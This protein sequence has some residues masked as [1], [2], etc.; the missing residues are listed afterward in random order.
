MTIPLLQTKFFIP[1]VRPELVPRGRLIERL[2][3]GLRHNGITGGDCC[4]NPG[5]A[6]KLTLISAPAGFGKTTLLSE[7]ARGRGGGTG[8]TTAPMSIAWLALDEGDNDPSRFLTYLI[9]AIQ[10]T[11]DD[12]GRGV[13]DALRSRHPPSTEVL[14]TA[15]INQI[16]AVPDDL[17]LIL[18]DYHVISAQP[19]HQ[20]LEFLLEH[21][22]DN[23]HIVIATRSD[24]PFRL[25]RL[26]GCGQ[27]TELRQTDLRFTPD[28][29]AAFLNQVMDLELPSDDVVALAQRTEG[30]IAGLQMAAISIHG[31]RRSDDS[32]DLS[33]FVEAFT[34]GHHFILD[35]LVEEVLEQQTPAIQEFL[36]KTAILDRLTGPLCDAIMEGSRSQ[37]SLPDSRTILAQLDSANLFL[38]PLDDE[39]CWYRYHHLFAELLRQRLNQAHPDS[40]GNL[41][42]RAS[43]WFEHNR[44]LNE[45][46][47]YALAAEDFERAMGLIE[48]IA[49][50]TWMQ[51]GVTTFLGWMKI[52]PDELVRTRPLLCVFHA[53]ALLMG[54]HPLEV[55]ISRLEDATKADTAGSV[56]GEITLVHALIATYRGNSRQGA[57]LSHRALELLPEESLFLRSLVAGILG[58]NYLY[59]GDV[60]AAS[61]AL[62]EAARMSQQVGNLMNSV[63]A[64]C[65]LAEL[66]Y[67]RGQLYEAKV[68][69]ER[70]LNLVIERHG[71]Q[72]PI[73]GLALIGLGALLREWND[74]EAALRHLAEGIELTGKLGEVWAMSG[75]TGLALLKQTLG[76]TVGA[77]EAIQTAQ[78]FAAKFD[79]TEVDDIRVAAFQALLWI[80]QGNIEAANHWAAERGLTTVTAADE[81]KKKGRDAP[82]PLLHMFEQITLARLYVAQGQSDQALNLLGQLL[83]RSEMA[84]W[85]SFAVEIL[86]LQSLIHQA[87]GDVVG[88]LVALERALFLAKPGVFV[89]IF[90]DEGEP[91]ARL[92][93]AA[94]ARGI[95]P[96]YAGRLLAAF[97]LEA[98]DHSE[99]QTAAP[100][101]LSR[102]GVIHPPSLIEPLSEREIE[103]LQLIDEGLSNQEVARRL[104]LSLHTVK[105]HTGNIYGKLGVKNR[106]QAVAKARALRVFP[107]A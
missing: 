86:I 94:A 106:M 2:N 22:P 4:E 98:K 35:Y 33:R 1:P 20:T 34:G 48:R 82:L 43:E 8:S 39:Q 70:A 11:A 52:L 30:W 64:L 72:Q 14:L 89:R 46:V 31:K 76:D 54:S 96:E 71:R 25:A 59:R 47:K 101:R 26:R 49:E 103:V 92:L 61:Q 90:V 23:L 50:T 69:W 95:V 74:L 51:G 55:V 91:M 12:V 38:V 78:Q 3:A 105:W 63:L 37:A 16:S 24:P 56:S 53:L 9:S 44:L 73:A 81:S 57:E 58:L 32:H 107:S 66:R 19:I 65:H 36:L 100:H 40:V 28:E 77:C 68:L 15:L 80:K 6:R 21:L 7:W 42:R 84:G 87:K 102:E 88:A 10:K 79:A 75:Y 27:L 93:Y 5:F 60:E 45:A 41:S 62:E 85:I 18:D 17:A 67:I 29:A 83:Q 97:E 99:R 13:L 104:F